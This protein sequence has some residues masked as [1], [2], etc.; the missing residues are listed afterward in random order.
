MGNGYT[1]HCP[2]CLWAK[3][4]DVEPGD[5]LA[6]CGG[7]MKPVAYEKMGDKER[8][9]HLCIKCGHEHKNKLAPEDNRDVLVE[10]IKKNIG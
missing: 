6:D 5:R 10:V 2:F 9:I 7:M 3:H 4:V 1:N 8:V